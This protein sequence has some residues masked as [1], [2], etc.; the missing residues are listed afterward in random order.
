M[1]HLIV[2]GKKDLVPLPSLI[3]R[4]ISAESVTVM[5]ERQVTGVPAKASGSNGV[6]G[7]TRHTSRQDFA[8]SS[9]SSIVLLMIV[10]DVIMATWHSGSVLISS[11]AGLRLSDRSSFPRRSRVS[12]R[13]S[14]VGLPAA[15]NTLSSRRGLWAISPVLGERLLRWPPS[16]SRWQEHL[17]WRV[18]ETTLPD[19]QNP[20][21]RAI[22]MQAFQSKGCFP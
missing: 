18:P 9:R 22:P 15:R 7:P 10:V 8:A 2:K 6:D 12:R 16:G 1:F 3:T 4:S 21:S 13:G 17:P 5:P 14:P 20:G 19:W 11:A